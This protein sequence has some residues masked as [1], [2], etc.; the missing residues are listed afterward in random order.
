MS[1]EL[2]ALSRKPIKLDENTIKKI[3]DRF[4]VIANKADDKTKSKKFQDRYDYTR[5]ELEMIMIYMGY[6]FKKIEN[7][8]GEI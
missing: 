1:Y 8:K 3:C 6:E 7:E 5:H 4:N 2:V